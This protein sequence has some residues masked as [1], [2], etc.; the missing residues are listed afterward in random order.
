MSMRCDVHEDDPNANKGT[1][2][3]NS[4]PWWTC[5]WVRVCATKPDPS[6]PTNDCQHTF[7]GESNHNVL[8]NQCKR[9]AP[10]RNESSRSQRIG[11]QSIQDPCVPCFV[12]VLPHHRRVHPSGP[13]KQMELVCKSRIQ[14]DGPVAVG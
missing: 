12:K 10:R 3:R 1:A 6:M 13:T 11:W 8:C 5:Q 14:E 7:G 2:G 9:V 4:V